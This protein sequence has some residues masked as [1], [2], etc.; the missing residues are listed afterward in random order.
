MVI[1][2]EIDIF[3]IEMLDN[4]NWFYD[5]VLVGDYVCRKGEVGREMYI[6]NRGK[7]EVVFEIGIKVYVVLEVGSYFGEISVL[8]MSVVGN[9]WIVLVCFVGYLELF[10]L[11]KYDF[12]EVFDEYLEIKIKIESIVK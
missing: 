1:G 2:S 12:M 8:C 5:F 7:L 3:F 6:V 11:L 10:C 9:C 4:C